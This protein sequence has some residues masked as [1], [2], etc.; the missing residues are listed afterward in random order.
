MKKLFT[1]RNRRRLHHVKR[2]SNEAA[3]PLFDNTDQDFSGDI[4]SDLFE[5]LDMLPNSP[6]SDAEK[7][8]NEDQDR[9]P[10]TSYPVN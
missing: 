2:K 9:A 1:Q 10:T 6:E 5:M 3:S 7:N 4:P 8:E